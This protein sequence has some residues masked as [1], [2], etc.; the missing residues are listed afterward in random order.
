M[1][2][3]NAGLKAIGHGPLAQLEEAQDLGSCQCAFESRE[4]Y[5]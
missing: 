2:R 5:A 1:H 3:D 4:V